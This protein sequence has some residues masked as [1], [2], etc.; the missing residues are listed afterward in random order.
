MVLLA[1]VAVAGKA[2][3]G[4]RAR[5]ALARGALVPV[6]T[7]GLPVRHVVVALALAFLALVALALALPRVVGLRWMSAGAVTD[8]AAGQGQ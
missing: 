2:Y 3:V 7:N 5:L 6:E 8:T 4:H 1:V